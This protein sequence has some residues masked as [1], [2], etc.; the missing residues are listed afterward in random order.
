MAQAVQKEGDAG[1]GRGPVRHRLWG[2]RRGLSLP[3][4]GSHH[5]ELSRDPGKN[6]ELIKVDVPDRLWP[7]FLVT[8]PDVMTAVLYSSRNDESCLAIMSCLPG[9]AR[10]RGNRPD[11]VL[12]CLETIPSAVRHGAWTG[13]EEREIPVSGATERV[14]VASSLRIYDQKEVRVVSL[15]NLHTE[16]GV[17]SLY[18]QSSVHSSVEDEIDRLLNSLR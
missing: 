15:D 10:E 16:H 6:G 8:R 1:G 18:Y 3:L 12:Q 13:T 5:R 9:W 17:I 2:G 14:R 11:Q 7:R 4:W